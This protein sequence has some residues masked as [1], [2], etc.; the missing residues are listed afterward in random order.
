MLFH[1]VASTVSKCRAFKVLRWVQILNRL[2]YL[3]ELLYEDDKFDS[4]SESMLFRLVAS[5]IPK[6]RMFKLRR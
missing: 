5:T 6:W 1:L 4:D 3:N 2:E